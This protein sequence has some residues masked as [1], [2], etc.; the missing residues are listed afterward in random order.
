MLTVLQYVHAMDIA[1]RDL[2]PEVHFS[3]YL[4]LKA[5][6]LMRIWQNI[7][8]RAVEPIWVKIADF[9]ESKLRGENRRMNSI[10]GTVCFVAPEVGKKSGYTS[11][12]DCF[13]LGGILYN[14]H[15]QSLLICNSLVLISYHAE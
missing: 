9:G 11:L 2:K 8:L 13:S 10:V 5:L 7:L 1:H 12:V 6:V 3:P 15:V 14:G 4:S